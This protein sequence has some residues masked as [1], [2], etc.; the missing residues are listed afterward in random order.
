MG[1]TYSQ[2]HRLCEGLG[3]LR[4]VSRDHNVLHYLRQEVGDDYRPDRVVLWLLDEWDDKAS[5]QCVLQL[6]GEFA[7]E[8]EGADEVDKGGVS[9]IAKDLDVTGAK[10]EGVGCSTLRDT[11]PSA[12]WSMAARISSAVKL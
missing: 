5:T 9:K 11:V 2:L 4:L 3:D 8:I 1:H 10:A 12:I 6:F 7:S